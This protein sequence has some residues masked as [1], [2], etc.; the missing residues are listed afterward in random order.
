MYGLQAIRRMNA[1]V[2]N[3]FS[4]VTIKLKID[5]DVLEH[6]RQMEKDPDCSTFDLPI[7]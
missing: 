4:E 7:C 1:M 5:T 3:N 2:W 6:L